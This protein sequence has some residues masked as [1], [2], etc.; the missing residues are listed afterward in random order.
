MKPSAFLQTGQATIRLAEAKP[1]MRRALAI[2]VAS[3]GADHP[4]SQTVM[5][6]YADLLGEM[7]HGE[8]EVREI[9]QSLQPELLGQAPT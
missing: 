5:G 7:G 9:F 6:N 8:E 1:L 2:C 3:L 4:N